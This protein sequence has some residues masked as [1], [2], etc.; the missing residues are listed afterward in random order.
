MFAFS[1]WK[2]HCGSFYMF[3]NTLEEQNLLYCVGKIQLLVLVMLSRLMRGLGSGHVTCGEDLSN[4]R[5]C[6]LHRGETYKHTDGRT[7]RL[8]D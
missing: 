7:S 8:Y 5:G 1:P 2:Q 3:G 4:A 6:L